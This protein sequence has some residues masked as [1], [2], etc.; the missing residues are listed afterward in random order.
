[1]SNIN[2]KQIEEYYNK[3]W[4][5]L[6]SPKAIDFIIELTCKEFKLNKPFNV[7]FINI[8]NIPELQNLGVI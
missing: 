7:N 2:K 5:E 1:M 8:K 4:S 6:I 3:E